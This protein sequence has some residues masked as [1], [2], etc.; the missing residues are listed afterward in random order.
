M[1]AR[2][3]LTGKRFGLWVAVARN[4]ATGYWDCRC[5]CGREQLIPV[6]NLTQGRSTGC[7]SCGHSGDRNGLRQAAI[8]RNGGK[9]LHS[10][11]KVTYWQAATIAQ[12]CRAENIPFGFST[13]SECA[14]WLAVYTPKVCPV[15]GIP[16][17]RGNWRKG[18][19]DNT[20]SVDRKIPAAGYV[21]DNMQVIS[22]KANAMKNNATPDEL[23]RFAEWVLR[24]FGQ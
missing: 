6:S 23:R 4:A 19:R 7:V 18:F 10:R 16:L 22:F 5:V 8:R 13:I 20:P 14:D 3:D 12:R 24:G 2:L 17:A 11:K 21:P 1:G 15:L 9:P